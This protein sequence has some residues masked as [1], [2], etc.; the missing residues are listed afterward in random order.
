MACDP[1][2]DLRLLHTTMLWMYAVPCTC[3]IAHQR[4]GSGRAGPHGK[5]F[6]CPWKAGGR[7]A[8]EFMTPAAAVRPPAL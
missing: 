3:V 2:G 8:D 6:V 5:T 4:L 1:R 7:T